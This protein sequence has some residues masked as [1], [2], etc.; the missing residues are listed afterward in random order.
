M[1]DSTERDAFRQDRLPDVQPSR[2]PARYTRFLAS[3]PGRSTQQPARALVEEPAW[4]EIDEVAT[5]PDARRWR[6]GSIVN[7][8]LP[9]LL[10]TAL[11]ATEQRPRSWGSSRSESADLNSIL[12][13]SRYGPDDPAPIWTDADTI[14]ERSSWK[15]E[16]SAGGDGRRQKR[17]KRNRQD[18]Q[19]ERRRD[20]GSR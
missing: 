5:L 3:D 16:T 15:D 19:G 7:S 11:D 12:G 10:R 20:Q 14:R 18:R 13:S 2:A 4:W 9:L 8:H 1:N 6:A 17:G